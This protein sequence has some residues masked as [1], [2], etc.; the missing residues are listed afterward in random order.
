MIKKNTR[1]KWMISLC[2]LSLATGLMQPGAAKVSAAKLNKGHLIMSQG[3]KQTLKVRGISGKVTWKSSNKKIAT[4]SQKGK[5]T[6]K[7]AG[8]AKIIAKI[9]SKKFICKITVKKGKP[10]VTQNPTSTQ[11]P[12]VTQNP[13]IAT[14]TP[15]VTQKPITATQT[16]V[17]TQ[18]PITATHTPVATRKPNFT[19]LPA[20]TQKPTTTS[21]PAVSSV[22]EESAYNTLNSLRSTYPE[23][24]PL[25]NSYYYYSPQ[26]GN[27]YGCYGFAAKLSDT[28]FGTATPYRTHSSFSRIKVGDNIRIGNSHS[29]I[30]LTKND[31]DITV[32]EGN[33]N[34]SV[35]W[36]R[37]ITSTSLASSGFTVY[38][39]YTSTR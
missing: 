18:N 39:R 20:T 36:D 27:G 38:T 14:Q 34:S 35:H 24:M 2:T 10:A 33:Y 23:G 17:A 37:K 5:V 26:F 8:K 4:V 7:K 13:T 19:W 29:V 16:P 11:K 21:S 12:I 22:T 25:T 9:K 15:V 1:K 30:V 28:I 3:K 32:V 31:N 6:A